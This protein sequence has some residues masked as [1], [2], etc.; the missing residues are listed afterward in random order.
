ME[1]RKRLSWHGPLSQRLVLAGLASACALLTIGFLLTAKTSES[2]LTNAGRVSAGS[3][4]VPLEKAPFTG[5][6]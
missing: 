2:S 1:Q 5:L 6:F 3:V 4:P